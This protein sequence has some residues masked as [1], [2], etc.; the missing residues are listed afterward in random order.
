MRPATAVVYNRVTELQA[1]TRNADGM[2]LN[3]CKISKA[4]VSPL[5][6]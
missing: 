6:I 5:L 2:T 4:R 3:G 1:I